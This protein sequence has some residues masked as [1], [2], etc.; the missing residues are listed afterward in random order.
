[1]FRVDKLL[2]DAHV[3]RQGHTK[4]ITGNHGRILL[5]KLFDGQVTYDGEGLTLMLLLANVQ[6]YAVAKVLG[7]NE[8]LELEESIKKFKNEI[9]DPKYQDITKRS[10][11]IHTL[12]A[13][14]V[15]FVK[16][17]K[18]WGLHSDQ[19]NVDHPKWC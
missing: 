17:H 4:K 1:M 3:I 13:H 5:N 9:I 18:S 7:E 12:I 6:K 15:P 16:I 11:H 14:V 2:Q 10:Q 8:I 19:C